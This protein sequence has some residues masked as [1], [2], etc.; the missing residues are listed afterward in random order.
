MAIRLSD[1]N[2]DGEYSQIHSGE[3]HSHQAVSVCLPVPEHRSLSY[4]YDQINKLQ[5]SLVQ[6][7]VDESDEDFFDFGEED[8]DDNPSGAEALFDALSAW[9]AQRANKPSEPAVGGE[10]ATKEGEPLKEEAQAPSSL[11]VGNNDA[12]AS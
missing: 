1:Y 3:L 10:T 4:Y 7:N 12:Q 2:L 6:K 8:F 9:R 5:A 11:S